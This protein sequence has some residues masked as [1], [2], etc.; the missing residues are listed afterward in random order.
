MNK[1]T[2]DCMKIETINK[3]KNR[4]LVLTNH[5]DRKIHGGLS[6]GTNNKI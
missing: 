6:S 1:I 2:E 5:W 3:N 4:Q